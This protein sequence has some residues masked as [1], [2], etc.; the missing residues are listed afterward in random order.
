MEF[1]KQPSLV[2]RFLKAEKYLVSLSSDHEQIIGS[3]V[4]LYLGNVLLQIQRSPQ[5]PKSAGK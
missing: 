4:L 1:E 3:E 2:N 5:T